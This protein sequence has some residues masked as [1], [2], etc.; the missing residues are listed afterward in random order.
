MSKFLYMIH[1]HNLPLDCTSN[2]VSKCIYENDF[3]VILLTCESGPI[4]I[5]GAL[6]KSDRQM[7]NFMDWSWQ[8]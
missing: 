4:I 8:R 7:I 5:N 1:P 6:C 3:S 2:T